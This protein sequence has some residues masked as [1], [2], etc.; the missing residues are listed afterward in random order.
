[1]QPRRGGAAGESAGW[2]ESISASSL[3]TGALLLL[4][5]ALVVYLAFN[6]GGFFPTTTAAVT[7]VLLALLAVRVCLARNPF[8]GFSPQLGIAAGALALYALWTLLSG[9]WSN[10]PGRAWVEFD[11]ALLYLAALV[12][13][14][15]IGRSPSRLRWMLRGVALGIAIVCVVA[16]I[17]RVLP[18]LWPVSPGFVNKRLS[19]P[20]T[21]WNTLGIM[22]SVGVILSFHLAASRSEPALVRV[23][24]AAAVP[25]IATTLFLTFSRGGIAAG[26]L[27]LV[28]YVFLARPRALL[29]GLL[30]TAPAT[31]VAVTTAYNADLLATENPTSAAAID[32]GHDVALVVGLCT[33]AAALV[34]L[35][36]LRF[37]RRPL[38]LGLAPKTRARLAS[39][40]WTSL[41]CVLIVGSFALDAPGYVSDQYDRFVHTAAP[42]SASGDVRKRLFDPSNNGRLAHWD[43]ALDAFEDARLHGE[44]AG[45]YQLLWAQ[46]R[47]RSLAELYVRDAHSLY[48]EVLGELGIVGLLLLVVALGTIFFRLGN[49]LRGPNRALYGALFATALAL[50]V[51]AGVDWDW[52]MPVV[53]IWLFALGGAAL[54]APAR[55]VR[56]SR[57]SSIPA[58]AFFGI[59][60]V[61]LALVPAH[62]SASQSRLDDSLD[63]YRSGDCGQATASARS[64]ISALGNRP[65][66]Y[67][68]IGYCDLRSGNGRDAVAE[69]EKAVDRDPEDWEYHYDL[70]LARGAS[71]VDPRPEAQAALRLDP[72]EAIAQEAVR[73]FDTASPREWKRSAIALAREIEL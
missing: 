39:A 42:P 22:A 2:W 18:E 64:S 37:D 36:M 25:P 38:R 47:P 24:G 66:P 48:V 20:V 4:P 17:T 28:A 61:L 19:Y 73:R 32:Q 52:E 57:L 16:L 58:R 43:V 33:V 45:T 26:V 59:A 1:V 46:H 21:Y 51:H 60:L 70:A 10:A 44:G 56:S 62:V 5:G 65:E 23:L 8:E 13:F 27:G 9:N 34:R 55:Q 12:L 29:T 3:A 50:A 6:A 14:G 53:M 68:V 40:A 67:E 41:A 71:G 35:V 54:A 7:L 31:I 11:R 49:G 63:A 30:A 15:S 72:L 69:M